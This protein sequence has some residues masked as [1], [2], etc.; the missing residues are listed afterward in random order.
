MLVCFILLLEYPAMAVGTRTAKLLIIK[1]SMI[2]NA[3]TQPELP[4]Q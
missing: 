4:R 2:L 1:R 3:P